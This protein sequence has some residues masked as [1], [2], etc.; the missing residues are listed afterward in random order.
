[1]LQHQMQQRA[2]SRVQ[3]GHSARPVVVVAHPP[4]PC[5]R[6]APAHRR[7]R[8]TTQTAAALSAPSAAAPTSSNKQQQ[9][10]PLT[11]P[12]SASGRQLVDPAH[13]CVRASARAPV[14]APPPSAAAS[15]TENEDTSLDAYMRLPVEQYYCL[16]PSSI[17]FLGGDRF[18]LSV[19]RVA[20]PKALGGLWVEPTVEVKVRAAAPDG[21]DSEGGEGAVVLEAER[22]FLRASPALEALKLDEKFALRFKARLTWSEERQK[23]GGEICGDARVD[24][25]SEVLAPFRLVPRPALE[26]ACSGVLASLARALLPVFLRQLSSDYSRWAAE[27]AYRAARRQRALA[28]GGGT[29]RMQQQQQQQQQ[30]VREKVAVR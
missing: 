29:E 22:C 21:G 12:P 25:Y 13:L 27:P 23:G 18:R 11:P 10:T 14:V 30:L 8:V 16:D 1:M 6:S 19:G 3:A 5:R 24:V 20:L 2:A 17:A 7:R 15:N 28:A 26:A 9:Q 4:P